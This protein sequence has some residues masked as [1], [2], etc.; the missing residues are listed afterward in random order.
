MYPENVTNAYAVD[1]FTLNS[2]ISKIIA[3]R[4]LVTF[5]LD[6]K[7]I[8]TERSESL[9]VVLYWSTQSLKNSQNVKKRKF[10]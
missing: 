6:Y 3:F 1:A 10:Y 8:K 5:R 2:N 9:I 7:K 4:L